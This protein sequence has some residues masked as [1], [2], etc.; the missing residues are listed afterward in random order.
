M[1]HASRFGTAETRRVAS[2]HS[3]PACSGVKRRDGR[4]S[5]LSRYFALFVIGTRPALREGP[6]T[7]DP[8]DDTE[9]ESIM[10]RHLAFAIAVATL[11]TTLAHAGPRGEDVQAPRGEDVQAARGEDVQAPRGEDVRKVVGE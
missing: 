4:C 1:K 2:F 11:T 5:S 6:S 7:S 3:G 10:I 9:L 8:N